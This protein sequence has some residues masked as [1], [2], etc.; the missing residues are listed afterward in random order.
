MILNI[1]LSV[2]VICLIV[3]AI[4]SLWSIR[5]FAP[6]VPAFKKDIQRIFQVADLKSGEVFYDLGCGDGRMVLYAG[7]NFTVQA[8]GIEF[9]FPLFVVCKIR[10]IFSGG[11]N[12]EFKKK[13]LFHEKI[14]SADVVYVFGLPHTLAQGLKEKFKKELK[15]GARVVS[16]AFQIQGLV[17]E[18]IDKPGKKYNA[19]YRYRF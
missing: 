16:Y 14:S 13:N 15:P 2:L 7:K 6:W 10:Q 19:I 3:L 4:R 8:I 9:L 1:F 12:I 11:K 17:P 5:S 18:V